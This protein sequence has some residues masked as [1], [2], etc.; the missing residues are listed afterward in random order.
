M[1]LRRAAE[2]EQLS[3]SGSRCTASAAKIKPVKIVRW[4]LFLAGLALFAFSFTLPSIRELAKPG[5]TPNKMLGYD[6][7][8]TALLVPWGKDGFT[9]MRS[10]PLS[11]FSILLSGWINPLFLIALVLALVRASWRV[12]QLLRIII[13]VMFIFCWIVFYKIHFRAYTGYW[14]WMAGV[15]LALWSQAGRRSGRVA[16]V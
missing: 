9:I 6:C 8:I 11:Y 15:L 13:P 10:D 4:I 1:P 5:A 2:I 14:V 16:R 3:K 12:N 7:A